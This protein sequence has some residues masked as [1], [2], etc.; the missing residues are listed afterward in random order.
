M[1]SVHPVPSEWAASAKINA[2][3]YDAMYAQSL[4]DPE[5]FWRKEAQRL[6]WMTPFTK[7]KNTSFNEA[8]F[9]IKW[10]EDGALNV[11]ANCIDRHVVTQGDAVAIL[12]EGDS[13]GEERRISYRELHEDTCR[14][15]NAAEGQWRA[16][17]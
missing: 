13:P 16:Q 12:W 2:E 3:R 8:D 7:V 14:F 9:G 11:S 6:D 15:A 1:S 5:G 17:G 4:S 10:F